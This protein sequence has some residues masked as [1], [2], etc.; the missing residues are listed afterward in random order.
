[1]N[2]KNNVY[3]SMPL[4]RVIEDS[5]AGVTK[6]MS[7]LRQRD[8]HKADLLGIGVEPEQARHKA[9]VMRACGDYYSSRKIKGKGQ[10]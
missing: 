8:P 5:I 1:M 2:S 9:G 6:A 4:N 10:K 7:A 3:M